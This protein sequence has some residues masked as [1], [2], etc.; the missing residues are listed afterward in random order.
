MRPRSLYRGFTYLGVLFSV[1]ILGTTLAFMGSS[2]KTTQQREDELE[3]LFVGDQFRRAIA[4]YYERTP[5][6]IKQYPKSF[7]QLLHDDRYVVPQRYLRKVFYDP[8]TK[9]KNWG[10]VR[11]PDGG[12]MGVYSLSDKTPRK[13]AKFST[14]YAEFALAK[15]FA[16]WKFTYT[17]YTQPQKNF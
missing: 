14:Q 12:I 11:A 5:G 16:D 3:L 10:L 1:A 17:P 13:R 9:Q 6:T 7:E 4:L 8:I 2:W 15:T